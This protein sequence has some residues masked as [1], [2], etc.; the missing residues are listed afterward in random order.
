MNND[1]KG[2]ED[3]AKKHNLNLALAEDGEYRYALTHVAHQAWQFSL[4]AE[5][6]NH[7]RDMTPSQRNEVHDLFCTWV[8]DAGKDYSL[9]VEPGDV[10]REYTDP[11]AV[12]AFQGYEAA[13][14]NGEYTRDE[15]ARLKARLDKDSDNRGRIFA[16]Y[17]REWEA[18]D[19]EIDR[20][21]DA[22]DALYT[23]VTVLAIDWHE[24]EE[25]LSDAV[26]AYRNYQPENLTDIELV[27]Q[28]VEGAIQGVDDHFTVEALREAFD[29]VVVVADSLQYLHA[30]D[31]ACD[32]V[33]EQVA[34]LR[35]TLLDLILEHKK[36]PGESE[37]LA[38][39]E[40]LWRHGSTFRD[41]ELL[42][43]VGDMFVAAFGCTHREN[44]GVPSW[45]I[46]VIT[47][48]EDG[49]KGGDQFG[50]WSI[51]DIEW[52][53]PIAEAGKLF[54]DAEPAEESR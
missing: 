10:E 35:V 48:T 16:G 19:V 28:A 23:E 38:A 39:N 2:F 27:E 44:P 21:S 42:C 14:L 54:P 45:D 52:W 3:Y 33:D 12:D 22:C 41:T 43:S 24:R 15:N 29:A 53:M 31:D 13:Y 37:A 17:R 25:A 50:G 7:Q 5:L 49:I 8:E 32:A 6:A 46:A 34:K 18:A 9:E 20:F 51:E 1:R 36:F 11:H 30:S 40:P 47:V 26:A 4:K